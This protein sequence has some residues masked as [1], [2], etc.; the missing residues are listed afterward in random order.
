MND[1]IC[2]NECSPKDASSHPISND[3][4]N[5][6]LCFSNNQS[7]EVIEA[8]ATET[9]NNSVVEEDSVLDSEETFDKFVDFL[10][11]GID[12]DTVSNKKTNHSLYQTMIII[13]LHVTLLTNQTRLGCQTLVI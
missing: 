12:Y 10:G 4:N 11:N 2:N 8:T 7:L 13:P 6:H 9:Q 1:E 3:K 5:K